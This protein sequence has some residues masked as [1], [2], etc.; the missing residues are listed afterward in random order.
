[1]SHYQ[2]EFTLFIYV[3]LLVDKTS[4]TVMC[5]RQRTCLSISALKHE[6]FL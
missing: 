1:M 6:L 5:I 2:M 3:E 4:Q